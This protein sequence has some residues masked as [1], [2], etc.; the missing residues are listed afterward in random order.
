MILRT[1]IFV[2]MGGTT[3]VLGHCLAERCKTRHGQRG[4]QELMG[5]KS[6]ALPVV[7]LARHGETAGTVSRQHTGLTD[8]IAGKSATLAKAS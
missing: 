8:P 7:Y 2:V 1:A 6:H 3:V 5:S 4:C